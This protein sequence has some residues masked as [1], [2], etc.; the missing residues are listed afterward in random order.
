[1]RPNGGQP[2]TVMRWNYGDQK[3]WRVRFTDANGRGYNVTGWTLIEV[4]ARRDDLSEEAETALL[5]STVQDNP[6]IVLAEPWT[7]LF[8]PGVYRLVY[9]VTIG[10]KKITFPNRR[11]IRLEVL[12]AL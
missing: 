12:P 8:T 4:I 11:H 7:F 1:M 6:A 5:L 2:A 10:G 3:S 9:R